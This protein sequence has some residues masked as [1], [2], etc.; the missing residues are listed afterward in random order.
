MKYLLVW[1]T[2]VHDYQSPRVA[3]PPEVENVVVG[4]H[5]KVTAVDKDQVTFRQSYASSKQVL[6]EVVPAQ[7]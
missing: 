2:V 4:H 7:G 6:L 3:Q 1:H 5:P